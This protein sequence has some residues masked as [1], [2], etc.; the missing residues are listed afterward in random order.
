[1]KTANWQT[2]SDKTDKLLIKNQFNTLL[3]TTPPANIDSIV[4]TFTN[5]IIEAAEST[6][7]KSQHTFVRK[8]VPWWN[9]E[10]KIVIQNYKKA[11]NKF[12]KTR[13][14]SDHITLKKFRAISRL[15]IN[16]SKKNSW[17]K[18]T[19]SINH[20]TPSILMWSKI[21]SIKGVN[22]SQPKTISYLNN[23]IFDKKEIADTFGYFFQLNNSNENYDTHFLSYKTMVENTSPI[24]YEIKKPDNPINDPFTITELNNC[25][26]K[27][28]SKS[29]GPDGIPF[30][31]LQHLSSLAQNC[32]FNIFNNIWTKNHFPKQWKA[33]TIILIPKPTKP[34]LI[35]IIKD[36][37]LF[38]TL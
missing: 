22:R 37:Y 17:K 35:S 12:R 30:L 8:K 1:M 10:C 5:T 2:F 25:L 4:K 7:G 18:F 27:K 26:S 32:L 14:Q 20:K 24:N 15:T 36:Q 9:N 33:V 13:F 3:Q 38:L 29:P 28:K 6:I 16:N 31:F 34:F 21:M 11:L 23:K 19:S